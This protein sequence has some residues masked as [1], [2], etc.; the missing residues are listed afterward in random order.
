MRSGSPPRVRGKDQ[1]GRPLQRHI[2]ITPACAG[3]STGDPVRGGFARDHPRVCGEKAQEAWRN[4]TPSGSP[5][6]V[7]GKEYMQSKARL[8]SRI[9]PACAWKSHTAFW[10]QLFCEDHP[11]V[12]GEKSPKRRSPWPFTGSPPRVR[13]KAPEVGEVAVSYRITPACAGKSV[14]PSTA[15]RHG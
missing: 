1:F 8:N 5:P 6:R 3:K 4:L 9:T 12:C 15:H 2:G 14:S 7:R 13:G 10:I 11:R